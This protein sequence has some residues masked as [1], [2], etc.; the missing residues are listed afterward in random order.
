MWCHLLVW[1][2]FGPVRPR[3]TAAAPWELWREQRVDMSV[4]GLFRRHSLLPWQQEPNGSVS[5][6]LRG[7]RKSTKLLSQ[8]ADHNYQLHNLKVM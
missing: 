6:C 8:L 2:R 5:L 7:Y 4:Y 3:V 1:K